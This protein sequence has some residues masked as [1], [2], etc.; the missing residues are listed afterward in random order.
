MIF[1]TLC[2][3]MTVAWVGITGSLSLAN[4]LLGL[5]VS[6]VSLGLVRHELP[7]SLGTARPVALLR[8]TAVFLR[9]LI[10]SAV[11]VAVI[12]SRP[13]L[14][15]TPGLFVFPLTLTRDFDI[16]LLANLITLTPGTLSVDVSPD[17]T[18]LTVHALDCHDPDALR[19]DIRDGF[20][21]LIRE[22]F[23]Q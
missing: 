7:R 9:E 12:V 14:E 23:P 21:R 3:L 22:A 16:A 13:K 19:R 10:V 11:R 1:A 17:R 20:E 18:E 5:A 15:L 8:L 4:L 2:L 6:A